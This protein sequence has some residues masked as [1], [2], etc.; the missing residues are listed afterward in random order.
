MLFLV[1]LA[2]AAA[3]GAARLAGVFPAVTIAGAVVL[4]GPGLWGIGGRLEPVD[5]PAGWHAADVRI[6]A[7]PGPVLALPWHQYLDIRAADGRR[8][9]NPM[10]DYLGGDVLSSSDPELSA[11]RQEEADPRERHVPPLLDRVQSGRPTADALARLGVR[12]VV[13][14]HEV[15]WRRMTALRSDPGLRRVYADRDVELFEVRSWRGPIV[16]AAGAAVPAHSLIAPLAHPRASS[17]ATWHRAAA[18]GWRRGSASADST[19]TGTLALP[20]GDGFV[21]FWPTLVV[22]VAY[23][24]TFCVAVR[25]W[26]AC[27]LKEPSVPSD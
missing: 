3:L 16:T 1:W 27:K 18:P 12:W 19:A 20:A 25:A 13:L 4:A 23:A 6:D 24:C 17:R 14:L 11:G 7:R 22:L 26:C 2:P 8:V 21:W 5:I 9:L 10:P 15:D